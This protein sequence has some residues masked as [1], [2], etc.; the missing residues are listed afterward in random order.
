[1]KDAN[2]YTYCDQLVAAR[3][4]PSKIPCTTIKQLR[5]PSEAQQDMC[6]NNHK[7]KRVELEEHGSVERESSPEDGQMMVEGRTRSTN[8]NKQQRDMTQH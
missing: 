3:R 2:K 6:C 8:I 7:K 1:M 5:S 4:A